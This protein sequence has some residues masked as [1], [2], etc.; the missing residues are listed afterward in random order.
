MPQI[1]TN[2]T[3]HEHETGSGS[4]APSR[5]DVMKGLALAAI[6]SRLGRGAKAEAM[7]GPAEGYPKPAP[8]T[9]DT[10]RATDSDP[11]VETAYGRIRGYVRNGIYAFKG[12]PYGADTSG[13]NRFLPAQR[14]KPWTDVRPCLYHGFVSPQGARGGWH[15]NEES[16]LFQW[17]DGTQSE[18]CLNLNVWTPA[19]DNGKR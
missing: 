8:A 3:M 12:V 13:A 17:D 10:V 6:G 9:G 14:P 1:E 15:N 4:I 19:L 18:D 2:G 7:P 5:R 11:V 16:W